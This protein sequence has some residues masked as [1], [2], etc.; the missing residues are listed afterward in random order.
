[1]H[2]PLI[3][4]RSGPPRLAKRFSW[5]EQPFNEVESKEPTRAAGLAGGGFRRSNSFKEC[6]K[7]ATFERLSQNAMFASSAD[8]NP[9]LF[10]GGSYG[11]VVSSPTSGERLRLWPRAVE[12]L[13][14]GI[15]VE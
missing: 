1:M 9:P 10:H 2:T 13:T 11:G 5:A 7:S 15:G 14:A 8:R 3:S 4:R 12:G 6:G